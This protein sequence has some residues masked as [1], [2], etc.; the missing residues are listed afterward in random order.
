MLHFL[1]SFLCIFSALG[2]TL[3]LVGKSY[4]IASSTM[5][6]VSGTIAGV[7]STMI[8]FTADKIGTFF[9]KFIYSLF[10]D[11]ERL[12]KEL[13]LQYEKA[14]NCREERR[15]EDALKI[16]DSILDKNPDFAD[17]LYLKAQILWDGFKNATAAKSCLNKVL[18]VVPR[19]EAFHRLASY[20]YDEINGI[21][22]L[23]KYG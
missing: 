9:S 15:F 19:N 4:G 12:Q 1:F 3:A 11:K 14:K 18:Q 16:V 6:L 20:Y 7:L 17:A 5:L 21:E 8:I 10:S 13:Y 22:K 23:T 2:I